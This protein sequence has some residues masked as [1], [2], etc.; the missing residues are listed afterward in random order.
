V[1]LSNLGLLLLR[2]VP[3]VLLVTVH[4][5]HKITA[6]IAYFR[7]GTPWPLVQEVAAIHCPFPVLT[8][9]VA[10]LLQLAGAM[11]IVLGLY[12]QL[13]ALV[14]AAILITALFANFVT[15]QDPQL[16]LLYLVVVCAIGLI[17]PGQW[18]LDAVMT[19]L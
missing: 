10:S 12:T 17:G 19:A 13:A 5:R 8:A 2:V 15:G 9:I 1:E 3:G 7:K 18:S 16:A 11:A 6:G 4:A 14:L